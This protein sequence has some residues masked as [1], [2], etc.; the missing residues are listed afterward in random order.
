MCESG[1]ENRSAR[2]IFGTSK[3][4]GTSLFGGCAKR[5]PAPK[6]VA[7]GKSESV[8]SRDRA[9][10]GEGEVTMA[11]YEINS[12]MVMLDEFV[13]QA[14][15]PEGIAPPTAIAVGENEGFQ[16]VDEGD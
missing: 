11:K 13:C 9:G 14:I 7:E 3:E 1:R 8:G 12:G 10:A 6:Y 2:E 4:A 15:Q 16:I 5:R